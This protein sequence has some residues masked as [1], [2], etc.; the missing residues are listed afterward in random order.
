VRCVSEFEG[1]EGRPYA[2]VLKGPALA[3]PA[4]DLV[5]HDS[6][7]PVRTSLQPSSLPLRPENEASESVSMRVPVPD[8]LME[9]VRRKWLDRATPPSSTAWLLPSLSTLAHYVCQRL[10][11]SIA[12][13]GN[14]RKEGS[15]LHELA[16]EWATYSRFRFWIGGG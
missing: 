6:V 7:R 10:I 4:L 9:A 1:A 16:E 14:A 12:K 11:K 3:L 2:F 8:P 15:S 13:A 5:C